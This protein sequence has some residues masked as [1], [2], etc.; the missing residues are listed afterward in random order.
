MRTELDYGRGTLDVHDF[1]LY[2]PDELERFAGGH[3]LEPAL[4][5][6]SCDESRAPTTGDARYQL[7]LDRAEPA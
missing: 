2:S 3:G 1:R 7:V 6:T 5:C 4:L